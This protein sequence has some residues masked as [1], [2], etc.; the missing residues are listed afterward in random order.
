MPFTGDQHE[1]ILLQLGPARHRTC[2]LGHRVGIWLASVQRH[3]VVV[4]QSGLT[5]VKVASLGALLMFVLL[6]AFHGT[7]Q[8]YL[9]RHS[10]ALRR[11]GAV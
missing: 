8:G 3:A 2:R 4:R 1:V 10:V 6:L 7:R 9:W 11:V 5:V